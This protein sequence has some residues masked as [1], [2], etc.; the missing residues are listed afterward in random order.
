M[1]IYKIKNPPLVKRIF[2]TSMTFIYTR[3]DANQPFYGHMTWNE[4]IFFSPD[5]IVGDFSHPELVSGSLH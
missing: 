1:E 3:M 4:H 2:L 5:D